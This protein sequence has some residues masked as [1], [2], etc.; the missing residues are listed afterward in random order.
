MRAIYCRRTRLPSNYQ[1]SGYGCGIRIATTE[2]MMRYL[3]HI[4]RFILAPAFVLAIFTSVRVN[5]ETVASIENRELSRAVNTLVS[6]WNNRDAE[7]I[8]NLFLSDAVLIMPTGKTTRSRS[9]IRERLLDE[10]S[11]KLKDSSLNHSLETVSLEGTNTAIVTGKYRLNGAQVLGME[12]SPEGKF[13]FKY[14]KG[15]AGWLLAE[16]QLLGKKS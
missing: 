10:W 11:G 2:R 15:K 12:K 4:S 9:A 1:S 5:A 3:L 13:I 6:A 14:A 8:A 7:K 16:A